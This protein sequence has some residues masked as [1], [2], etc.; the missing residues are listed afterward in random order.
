MRQKKTF[1]NNYPYRIM[2]L[3]VRGVWH[4]IDFMAKSD[5]EAIQK[6]KKMRKDG[7]I[8]F[9]IFKWRYLGYRR[10]KWFLI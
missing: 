7:W 4:N 9:A 8:Q 3:T 10:Y 6:L 5:D 2:Y 1:E